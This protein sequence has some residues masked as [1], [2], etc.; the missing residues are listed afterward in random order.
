MGEVV[1]DG[2]LILGAVDLVEE[3]LVVLL[4]AGDVAE[5]LVQ[6]V[7]HQAAPNASRPPRNP[8]DLVP[9]CRRGVPVVDHVVIIED[10]GHR[11]AGEEPAECRGRPRDLVQPGV[12]LEARHLRP[13]G[14]RRMAAP[15]LERRRHLGMG[16]IGVDLVTEEQKEIG[17]GEGFPAAS[18]GRTPGGRRGRSHGGP[19]GGAHPT[20][21][22][23]APPGDTSRT[24]GGTAH[25]VPRSGC[26]RAA[27]RGPPAASTAGRRAPPRRMSRYP[28]SSHRRGPRRSG[29]PRRGTSAHD[30]P[31]LDLAGGVRLDPDDRGVRPAPGAEPGRRG[32]Q[33]PSHDAA[34]DRSS[35][36][37]PLQGRPPK[38]GPVPATRPCQL[39]RLSAPP[40]TSRPA[41][42]RDVRPAS[43]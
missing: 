3:S 38:D 36:N 26:C 17:V 1:E 22:V 23:P 28:A 33:T 40:L 8:T 37:D 29:G 19:G 32:G 18:R 13:A 7:G 2:R 16:L 9:P 11:H 42:R 27:G 31:G 25:P 41:G 15:P 14:L 43:P 6:P 35:C 30:G 21:P 4:L 24:G 12:L 10:H 39:T 20:A 5:V 34:N